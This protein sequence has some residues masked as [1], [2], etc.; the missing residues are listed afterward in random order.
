MAN[1][2]VKEKTMYKKASEELQNKQDYIYH[3]IRD[4]RNLN[5]LKLK[6]DHKIILFCLESRGKDA[7][8][9]L[10]TLAE[11]CGFG[12]TKL[13]KLLKELQKHEIVDW[14]QIPFGSNRY[15]I[16]RQ[17]IFETHVNIMIEKEESKQQAITNFRPDWDIPIADLDQI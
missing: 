16:N 15:K 13:I 8:P 3:M 5:G 12:E 14:K 2:Q 1:K 6:S 17:L 10:E 7:F 4:V 9:S 11:D